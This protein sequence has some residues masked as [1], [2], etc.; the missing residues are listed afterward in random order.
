MSTKAPAVSVPAVPTEL[1]PIVNE[2]LALVDWLEKAKVREM[3]ARQLLAK[4]FFPNPTEGVNRVIT[5]D[6]LEVK[7]TF[8]LYRKLEPQVLDAVMEQFPA[9]SPYRAPDVLITYKP[10]IVISGLRALPPELARVFAQAYTESPG[11][12]ALEIALPAADASPLAAPPVTHANTH[13]D[14]PASVSAPPAT[15]VHK[16]AVALAAKKNATK[17]KPKKSKK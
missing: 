11:A 12:P 2:W 15:P 7:M 14:F 16:A 5:A 4:H 13:A 10:E 1:Q 3:E 17:T 8:K 6:G 9:N